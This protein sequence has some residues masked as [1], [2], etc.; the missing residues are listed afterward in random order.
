MYVRNYGEGLDL[1][2]QDVFQ[3][4]DRSVVE[5]Y[6]RQA[7]TEFEW[8]DGNRLRTRQVRQVMVTHPKTGATVWFNHAHMFHLSNLT[9]AVR[10]AL[11]AEFTEKYLPRNAYYGDGSTIE[12]SVLEEIRE[13]YR[14]SAVVF[15]W[16]KGDVL[17]LDNIL[18]S[19]GRHPYIGSRKILVSMAEL[20][21]NQPVSVGSDYIGLDI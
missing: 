20:Y 10:E 19:H 12:S 4:N 15:E 16:R 5:N 21:I 11:L 9:T 1:P 6:C 3:T 14:Q 13:I 17:M 8:V 7:N 18:V 2:W